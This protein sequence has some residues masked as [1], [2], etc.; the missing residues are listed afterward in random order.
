M[1]FICIF[2]TIGA[3]KNQRTI[4]QLEQDIDDSLKAFVRLGRALTDIRDRNLYREAGYKN[5]EAYTLSRWGHRRSWAYQQ[6]DA[7]RV[8]GYL[9]DAGFSGEQM[10]TAEA[11]IRNMAKLSP[12]ECVEIW[13][14]ALARTPKPTKALITELVNAD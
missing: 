8:Y 1:I 3:M 12:K 2:V 7:A 13:K 14:Q 11:T 6:M 5:L 4:D 9:E 10:P